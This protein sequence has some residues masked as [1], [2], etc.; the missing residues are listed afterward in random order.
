MLTARTALEPTRLAR[1]AV[2][3][4]SVF[5]LFALVFIA[6]YAVLPGIDHRYRAVLYPGDRLAD[7]I[8]RRF[9]AATGQPLVYVIGT[10]WD[11]GNV[12]HYAREQPRVLIDGD[13]RRAPWIDLGDLRSKGAA[14][15]WTG[16]DPTVMPV[17][18]RRIAADA[19]VQAPFTLPF[20][21]GGGT[22]TVGWAILRPQPA[23]AS[24]RLPL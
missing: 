3:W 12:A 14:V 17:P 7:E 5:V 9:R 11:G 15:M 24:V 1:V 19:Q 10:M 16:S 2:S 13:P 23:F 18:L 20:R 8:A 21:R 6:N 4:A 22:L